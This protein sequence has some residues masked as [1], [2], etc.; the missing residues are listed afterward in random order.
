MGEPTEEG[1]L[2]GF[3]DLG[4]EPS[5]R[6]A[7]CLSVLSRLGIIYR[8]RKGHR[9]VLCFRLGRLVEAL[10]SGSRSHL[11]DCLVARDG[12]R[13]RQRNA[14]SRVISLS[15]SPDLEKDFLEELLGVLRSFKHAE[16]QRIENTREGII[17]TFKGNSITFRDASD[18]GGVD[19]ILAGTGRIHLEAPT[20]TSISLPSFRGFDGKKNRRRHKGISRKTSHSIT[21]CA[22]RSPLDPA[23]WHIRHSREFLASTDCQLDIVD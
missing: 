5:Q 4:S 7:D 9:V 21:P 10:S 2:D 12:T 8:L 14:A 6:F 20:R 13:P 1:Q 22:R 16:G 11:I 17:N 3:A 18:H 15:I 19:L 23:R